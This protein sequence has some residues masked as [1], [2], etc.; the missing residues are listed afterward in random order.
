MKDNYDFSK[1]VKNPYIDKLR[2][3]YSVLIHY[4]FPE[5]VDTEELERES[6]LALDEHNDKD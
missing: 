4:D 1:G 6:G 2:S 5:N 3:G